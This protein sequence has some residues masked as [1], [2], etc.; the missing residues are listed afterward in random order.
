MK[1]WIPALLIAGVVILA[2]W[3]FFL[4]PS[5]KPEDQ[6]AFG[7]PSAVTS[8]RL[9]ANQSL[10]AQPELIPPRSNAPYG[11]IA[12]TSPNP[13]TPSLSNTPPR[14]FLLGSP[15]AAPTLD[16]A[17]VLG[18]MR[19]VIAR[20]GSQFGGNPVGTNP[21]ITAA[22]NGD[23]P[24]QVK[25]LAE[26]SGLRINGQGEL[27]DTWGTPFFFHQISGSETEIRSAGPDKKM[28]TADDLVTK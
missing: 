26:D 13:V 19:N 8:N 24:K 22:L 23:N 15:D 5:H 3:F 9:P 27:I 2:G 1:G 12:A 21:E 11:S 20:Y 25:F 17:V 16:P 6:T 18:N 10:H 28:W 7:E 4:R 14:S